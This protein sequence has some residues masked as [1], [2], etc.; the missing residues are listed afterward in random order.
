[1]PDQDIIVVA[2]SKS[3]ITPRID[4]WKKSGAQVAGVETGSC[5]ASLQRGRCY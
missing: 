2:T 3:T 5:T 4:D 1:M